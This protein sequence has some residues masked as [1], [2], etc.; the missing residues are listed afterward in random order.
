MLV[1]LLKPVQKADNPEEE[2]LLSCLLMV[3]VAVSLPR[4]ARMEGSQYLASLEGHANNTHCLANA[5]NSV[6]GALFSITGHGDIEDRL[7]EFLALAS[8]SLLR[9][10]QEAEKE[11]V[12]HRDSIYLLLDQIVQ[13]SPFLSMDLMESCF[14]YALLRMSYH[15]VYKGD[16]VHTT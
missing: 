11:A 16:T 6:F 15:S 13:A 7:K 9:L 14:P 12:K 2:Y 4:L 10:G 1:N 5:V 3:L 8:S